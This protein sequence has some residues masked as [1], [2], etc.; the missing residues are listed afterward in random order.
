[1]L[2]SLLSCA[3]VVAH[4]T[5]EASVV[6]PTVV[7]CAVARGVE[8]PENTTVTVTVATS[9]ARATSLGPKSSLRMPHLDHYSAS[10]KSQPAGANCH[11]SK[12]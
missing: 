10:H 4:P 9:T 11:H 12:T 6:R 2:V 1:M 7:P 3:V 8:P 5:G